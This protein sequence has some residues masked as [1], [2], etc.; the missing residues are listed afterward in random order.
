MPGYLT[1]AESSSTGSTLSEDGEAVVTEEGIE[2]TDRVTW[3]RHIVMD[4]HLNYV[5][6]TLTELCSTA[7]TA[8]R[9]KIPRIATHISWLMSRDV[10]S[11]KEQAVEV[12][13]RG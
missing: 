1:G 5:P 6:K 8:V 11:M 10:L 4:Q 9:E 13:R 12:R 2:K 3:V 7:V